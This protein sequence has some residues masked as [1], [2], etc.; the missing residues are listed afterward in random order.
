MGKLETTPDFD[1]LLAKEMAPP[2]S[3]CT[4]GLILASLEESQRAKVLRAMA[5]PKTTIPSSKIAAA[6]GAVVGREIQPQTLARHR[7]GECRCG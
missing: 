1:D 5:E 4:V 6:L 2:A 7:R 3:N